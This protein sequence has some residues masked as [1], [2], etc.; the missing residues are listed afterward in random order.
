MSNQTTVEVKQGQTLLLYNNN[1]ILLR[2]ECNKPSKIVTS[3][4]SFVGT[5]KEVDAK[6]KELSLSEIKKP[7]SLK[8]P[9]VIVKMKRIGLIRKLFN[10]LKQLF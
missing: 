1:S 4:S 9:K 3:W 8:G 5:K 2:K 6:I 7:L 10:Y